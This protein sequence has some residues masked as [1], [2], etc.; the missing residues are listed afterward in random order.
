MSQ[1]QAIARLGIGAIP[2]N[3]PECPKQFQLN[4]RQLAA[5]ELL[6]A[7]A[8]YG[9]VATT[10]GIDRKTLY[11]WRQED[12]FAQWLHE[13]RMELWAQAVERMQGLVHP[14]LDVMARALESDDAQ[15]RAACAILKLANVGKMLGKP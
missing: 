14:S 1:D 2:Q 11:N 13:R 7:G 10:I 15:F 8:S 3:S 9:E 12:D 4:D 5:I 6:A